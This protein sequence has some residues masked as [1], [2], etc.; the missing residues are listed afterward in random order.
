M[1]L[2]RMIYLIAAWAFIVGVILQLFFVGMTVVAR[3]WDWANH[4]VL[5]H[6]L[7]LPVLVMVIAVFTGRLPKSMKWL[8]LALFGVY[9]LQADVIIFLRDSAPLV[10]ALHPVLALADFALGLYLVREAGT[11]FTRT[12]QRDMAQATTTLQTVD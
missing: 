8:T 4:G 10:S 7:G 9:V 1:K 5:G 2:S 6:A 11:V 12:R 3:Q